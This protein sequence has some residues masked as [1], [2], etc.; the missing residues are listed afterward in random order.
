LGQLAQRCDGANCT[1]FVLD[2][3]VPN[4]RIVA[5]L[6]DATPDGAGRRTLYAYGPLGLAAVSSDKVTRF[7]ITDELG[8]VRSLVSANGNVDARYA[9]NAYGELRASAASTVANNI[10]FAGEYSGPGDGVQWLRSRAYSLA[11][12]CMVVERGS[13]AAAVDG[14]AIMQTLR[15]AAKAIGG[16]LLIVTSTGSTNYVDLRSGTVVGTTEA[17]G[18]K[19]WPS[20]DGWWPRP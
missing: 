7:A 20:D 10:G 3:S 14:R 15:R 19:A 5:E 18:D 8:S 9:Y 4:A 17:T 1:D 6:G 12:A 16:D 2:E 11:Y 13:S